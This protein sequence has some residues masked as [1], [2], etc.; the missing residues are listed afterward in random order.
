MIDQ[1]QRK[2]YYMV[3]GY[4]LCKVERESIDHVFLHCVKSRVLRQLLFSLF[5][6]VWIIPSTVK[7]CLLG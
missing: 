1:L 3:N 4:F 2:G 7:E 6:V 5:G